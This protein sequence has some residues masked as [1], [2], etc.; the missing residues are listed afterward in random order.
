MKIVCCHWMNFPHSNIT[1]SIIMTKNE[2]CV[3]DLIEGGDAYRALFEKRRADR[4]REDRTRRKE[5][6]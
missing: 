1:G 2:D 5:V 3:I 6:P 4:N